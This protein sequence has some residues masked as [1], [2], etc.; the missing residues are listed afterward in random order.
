MSFL[1][2]VRV[3][4]CDLG[5]GGQFEGSVVSLYYPSLTLPGRTGRGLKSGARVSQIVR[6]EDW[7]QDRTAQKWT[8]LF[9][10]RG[11]ITFKNIQLRTFLDDWYLLDMWSYRLRQKKKQKKKTEPLNLNS[12]SNVY[13]LVLLTWYEHGKTSQVAQIFE[14]ESRPRASGRRS[15]IGAE[16]NHCYL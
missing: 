11:S 12:L 15:L 1:L 9:S 8:R 7:F 4:V 13:Y 10:H 16:M 5:T 3:R 2:R 14:G 6:R